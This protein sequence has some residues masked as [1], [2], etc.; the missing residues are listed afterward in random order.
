MKKIG[1][2]IACFSLLF[3]IKSSYAFNVDKMFVIADKKGN[4]IITLNNDESRPIFITASIQELKIEE[5][6]NILRKD[7]NRDNIDDWK[8]SITHP[9]LVLK[10]GESRDIGIRSLCHNVSC[11]DSA[12]LMFRLPFSP[13][14]YSEDKSNS[15][16]L[17]VNYGFAPI[18]VIPTSKPSYSYNIVNY[19]DKLLVDNKSNTI[20]RFFVNSCSDNNKIKCRQRYT[21]L[22]GRK[23]T[24]NL[25]IEIQSEHLDVVVTS[26][27]RSYHR[28]ETVKRSNQDDKN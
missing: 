16:S 17:E 11:D 27:D 20:L 28:E 25:P 18:Y 21:L 3:L 13:Q 12:D 8:I 23:K 4:G 9:K 6:V 10:S 15:N 19:G 26:H 22:A 2:K 1:I 14:Y 24:F 7:Y 5:G